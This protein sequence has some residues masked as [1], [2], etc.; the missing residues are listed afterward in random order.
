M[1][2]RSA[3][4]PTSAPAPVMRPGAAR[5]WLLTE[6]LVLGTAS[7]VHAG[8]LVPG[9]A[10]AAART[11]EAVIATVLVLAAVE[12]WLRPHDARRAALFGQGFALLGTLVGLGTIVAGIG[13][14]T[15][16]DVVFHALLLSLLVMGLTW[17]VRCR[18]V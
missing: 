11:A 17:A 6:A 3:P 9:Y 5:A 7:M 14:H 2:S 12:T 4:T 1:V 15:V 13:P 10:H 16:P 18:Q 8:F